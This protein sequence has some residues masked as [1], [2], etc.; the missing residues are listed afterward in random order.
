[1]ANLSI[2]IPWRS[3]RVQSS[4]FRGGDTFS[5]NVTVNFDL[6]PIDI[7]G[8]LGNTGTVSL[9]AYDTSGRV[10]ASGNFP[11]EEGSSEGTIKI[12]NNSYVV[13]THNLYFPTG[14]DGNNSCIELVIPATQKTESIQLNQTK[15][16]NLGVNGIYYYS[17]I[18]TQSGIYSF[19]PSNGIKG[20]ISSSKQDLSGS[21]STST[22]SQSLTS[23]NTYYIGITRTNQTSYSTTVYSSVTLSFTPS[24][25]QIT[26]YYDGNSY[27][28]R[29]S[30]S[31]FN[32]NS[33]SSL[34]FSK[35]GWTFIGW[36]TTYG[37]I[38]TTYSD[39]ARYTGTIGQ[40]ANL[41]AVWQKSISATAYYGL[42]NSSSSILTGIL[43]SYN[44]SNTSSTEDTTASVSLPNIQASFTYDGRNFLPNS[45]GKLSDGQYTYLPLNTST[46]INGGESFYLRYLNNELT[47]SYDKNNDAATGEMDD[48]VS[49]QYYINNVFEEVEFNVAAPLFVLPDFNFNSWNTNNDGTGNQYAPNSPIFISSNTVLYAIWGEISSLLLYYKYKPIKAFLRKNNKYYE[50]VTGMMNYGK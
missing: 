10:V 11:F 47:L 21:A 34:G 50:I 5:G 41:Y 48:S 19:T 26:F 35:T 22:V 14:Q 46:S 29:Y 32:L 6:Y 37:T 28:K 30:G 44:T 20:W 39:G 25:T 2:E 4:V 15:T 23:G 3:S 42:N 7:I 24:D 13:A 38:N 40:A 27:L 1:M 16:C 8:N 45:W 18:P 9:R 31:S 17:F 43:Y 33:I 49:N 36:A 12:P